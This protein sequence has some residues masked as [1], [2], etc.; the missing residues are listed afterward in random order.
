MKDS[1][2][3]IESYL[4]KKASTLKNGKCK[5]NL[6]YFCFDINE[7]TFFYKDNNNK[8]EIKFHYIGDDI[9]KYYNYVEKE[10]N[11]LCD[12]KFGFRIVTYDKTYS[13]FAENLEIY[14]KWI[15]IL[16]L[17]FNSKTKM[18]HAVNEMFFNIICSKINISDYNIGENFKKISS[19]FENCNLNFQKYYESELKNPR[20]A[21]KNK[22]YVFNN[23]ISKKMKNK[24]A[25]K[26][27]TN[28]KTQAEKKTKKK[29]DNEETE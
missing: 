22:I 16:N 18:Y 20:I 3:K 6:R 8:E 11:D 2:S 4:I 7:K 17:Y 15:E 23:I 19:E 5:T 14:Q 1:C 21:L 9:K 12:L 25:K 13:L 24:Q 10:E 29:Q 27:T 26:K 28:N